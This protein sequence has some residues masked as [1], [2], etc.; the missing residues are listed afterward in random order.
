VYPTDYQASHALARQPGFP[1]R[2]SNYLFAQKAG[3]ELQDYEKWTAEEKLD[4]NLATARL[5]GY[6]VEG[7]GE[8]LVWSAGDY[9]NFMSPRRPER[10]D[11]K[12]SRGRRPREA[13]V[14]NPHPCDL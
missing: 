4:L 9:E 1:L 11:G 6:V 12:E 3:T 14:A 13:P 10:E 2:I 7:A 8:N 5:N